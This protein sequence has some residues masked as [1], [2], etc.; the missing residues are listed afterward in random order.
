MTDIEFFDQ[1]GKAI[2]Y[3][4]DGDRIYSW[5]GQAVGFFRGDAVYDNRGS[6]LG[7]RHN[8]WI[9]D[10]FGNHSLFSQN[11]TGGPLKPL[12]QLPPLKGLRQLA[13]MKPLTGLAGMK[14]FARFNWGSSVF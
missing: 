2:A 11:A 12:R 1:Q 8:G 5:S 7:W 14:P 6:H 3:S 4:P 10:R 13:P 9:V